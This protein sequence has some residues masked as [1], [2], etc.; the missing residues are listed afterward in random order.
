MANDLI[1]NLNSPAER[2][3]Q[4]RLRV[5]PDLQAF[6]QKYEGKSFTVVK[7]PVCL[8]Y[9]RFNKQEHFVFQLFD[10]KHTMEEVQEAFEDEFKPMRLEQSDL[11]GFARQLVTAGLVQNEQPGAARH[12]FQRRA[13][14]RRLRRLATLSNILYLKIPVFDPDRLLTWMF[15]YLWWVFTTWFFAASV[16]LML[17]AVVHVTLHFNTFQAKLPAYQ[18]FFTW[19]SV[20]YMWLSLGVVKV[21]HEFGH[22]LSCKAFGGECHEMGVL[23]MCLSPALYAN[24][25]DAWTLADKW[26][27]IIISFAGIYVELVIASIATFVWWYTPVYPVINNIAL[28]IMVLCSVSTVMFNANPLMRFDGYYILAD[29]LEVPNLREKANKYLNNLFQAK[30][31]GIDVPPEAYMAPWRKWLFV[32]Y[33]VASWVYRWV[34][35]FSILWFF[36]DF[37][38]PKLKILSQMLAIMSLASLFVWPGYK[39]I[40][41][42][43]QRGRLPDMKAARVYVTLAV[44]SALLLAFFFLPLPVSRVHET[45]LVAVDPDALDAVML[46]EPARLESL[47]DVSS[48][49]QV[50]RGQLLGT[51]K[52]DSLEIELK[53]AKAV[54]NEQWRTVDL[55][56]SSAAGAR[57]TGN[58]AADKQY[59]AE[60]KKAR[61]KAET[62][63]D[64]VSRLL[65]RK[66]R[67]DELKAPRDGMLVSAPKRDDIGKLYDK[68]YTDAPP[69]FAVGDP[70]RLVLKVPVSP[71]HFRVL[72]D[73]LAARKE[74]NVSIYVKGRSDR[75]FQGKLRK[76]PEQNAATV[77]LALTQRGGGSLAVKPSED[78]N[79]LI[80]L[81]QVY[82]VEVE[83]TDPDAA[84]DPGQLATVKVHARWRSGAWWVARALSNSLDIGLY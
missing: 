58:D 78:P 33:A 40:K 20:L 51:F 12:L 55:M 36:A 54:S 64:D 8:R 13:K 44:F 45:G 80:P 61:A 77:P 73:D 26:K 31:L 47:A 22:G 70:G 59:A 67:L 9:Y 27:R 56:T 29:W 72:K 30:C 4:V 42:I 83:M 38:G 32:I 14:Q 71:L 19:N 35:T 6:E 25:T 17:A 2:R 15:R 18:E 34:V 49:Q 75:T 10:G 66:S 28:C 76:L 84:V 50:R 21:I 53:K 63:D 3:K 68:G 23:L 74:L 39:L 46:T 16:G 11:E 62:A 37:M 48:G 60:A 69:V 52:S 81:A 65:M 1:A 7:D 57:K 41:N 82:L 24:V 5:R 79:V 43:R